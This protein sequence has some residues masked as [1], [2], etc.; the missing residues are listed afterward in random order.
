MKKKN[1]YGNYEAEFK[2]LIGKTIEKFDGLKLGEGVVK[3]FTTDGKIYQLIYHQDCCASCDLEDIIGDPNDLIGSPLTMADESTSNENPVGWKS[4]YQDSFTWC[5]YK[6]ATIKGYVTLRFY[7]S[8]N[9]YYSE[10]M[11]FEEIES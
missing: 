11:D 1:Y 4:K 10:T 2:D 5:F 7:G 6:L 8:S 9:G 3:I